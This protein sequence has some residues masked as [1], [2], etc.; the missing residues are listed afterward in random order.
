MNQKN[1]F[2]IIGAVL[3]LQGIAF[4]FMGDKI[5]VDSFPNLDETG[6]HATTTLLTVVGTLSIL[7]GLVT[8]AARETPAVLWAYG[9]G[10]LLLTANTLKHLLVDHINVPTFAWVLQVLILLACIYLWMQSR[11]TVATRSGVKV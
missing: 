3:V 7:I 8:Y 6:I 11:K 4:F 5:V 9:I 10:T 2:T 1:L